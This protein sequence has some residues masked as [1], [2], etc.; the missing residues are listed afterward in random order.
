MYKKIKIYVS[1]SLA[2]T[3]FSTLL[4]IISYLISFDTNVGYLNS[5]FFT[6][7]SLAIS[8]LTIIWITTLF[9]VIPKSK[10]ECNF[11][12]YSTR[13]RIISLA[14]AFIISFLNIYNFIDSNNTTY[15]S[16]SAA[17]GIISSLYF[18]AIFFRCFKSHIN[19]QA[20][21]GIFPILF[22]TITIIEI[23]LNTFVTMNSPLKISIMLSSMSIMMYMLYEM[24]LLANKP[25]PRCF[26]VVSLIS[27]L[28]LSVC[29]IPFVI[30][31]Y[32]NNF[33]QIKQS[34]LIIWLICFS[35]LIYIVSRIF[36]ILYH[37][38]SSNIDI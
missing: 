28:L 21:L 3:V 36:D 26:I 29:T 15:S 33:T 38:K 31:Y 4:Y 6:S 16:S 9:K 13:T 32:T 25:H 24:R 10:L 7:V 22:S 12:N 30:L 8:L 23:H 18:F 17:L 14:V 11:I 34:L 37:Y 20:I 5:G 2:L 35:I 1:S 19:I 27:S